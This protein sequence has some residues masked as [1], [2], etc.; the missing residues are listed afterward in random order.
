MRAGF[1]R[2]NGEMTNTLI[3]LL[4]QLSFEELETWAGSK[5]LQRARAYEDRV[6]DLHQTT[7][8]ALIAWVEGEDRY[9]TRV[10]LQHD[11]LEHDCTCPYDWGGPCK[12]A[13][14]VILAAARM[15][16]T[17]RAIP[18]LETEED[19]HR[20]LPEGGKVRSAHPPADL[21]APSLE[22][23][24]RDKKREE[25][26]TLLL[27][28]AGRYPAVHQDIME[29][30]HLEKGRVD[31]LTE[32]LRQE[33]RKLT[34][35]PAWYDSW[36]H[37]GE[38][39]DY[40]H[41]ER[42]MRALAGQ[43]H[44]DALLELGSELWSR[45]IAQ[46]EQSDDEGAT[47]DAIAGCLEIIVRALPQSSLSPPEQL[48]WVIDHLLE[49]EYDLLAGAEELLHRRQYTRAHWREVAQVLEQRLE[50]MPKPKNP[51]FSAT[52]A[53]NNLLNQVVEAYARSGQKARIVPLLEREADACQCYTRLVEELLARKERDQARHWCIR[54]YER[55][56]SNA[57]GIAHA[58]Q[59]R[60]RE[61]AQRERRYPLVAAYR[62]Q[63]F[64]ERPSKEAYQTLHKAAERAGCWP[65]VREAVLD[66][67]ETG[68]LP[69]AGGK[70]GGSQW[71]LPQPEIRPPKMNE[72]MQGR[73]FPDLETLI[74][75]AILEKRLDDVAALYQRLRNRKRFGWATAERVADALSGSRPEIALGIWKEIAESL[76]GQVKPTAY[77]K[78]A[79]YLKKMK[80]LYSKN[81]QTGEWNAFLQGLRKRHKAKRRLMEVLDTLSGKKLVG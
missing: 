42:Q 77:V 46:V 27:D 50:A 25:L 28:I 52:Y 8:G 65:P 43:G 78:A 73:Y 18:V 51:A 40:S 17:K 81:Q 31:T 30:E 26:L 4:S 44:A 80:R 64:F 21:P 45:G 55:T 69:A 75:I 20:M 49:D 62:A 59:E 10:L 3:Q 1:K 24:L 34:A 63:E 37:R 29:K 11:H 68:T 47:A 9:V 70:K 74:D 79:V 61:L 12:H 57:P 60:L 58:L 6:D 41:L 54:G 7:C 33:I 2:H 48:L 35:E 72:R 23:I 76:I 71:P 19:P 67:L 22:E 13:V 38:L 16:K 15:L 39:P 36:Q 56:I 53:R 66:Y 14:A 5:I 32:S